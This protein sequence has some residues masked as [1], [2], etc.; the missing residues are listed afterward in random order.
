[1]FTSYLKV[2]LRNLQRSPGQTA[3]NVAG[4]AV[5][6]ACCV[7]IVLFVQDEQRFDRFHDKADRIYRVV[8]ERRAADNVSHRATTPPAMGP[9]LAREFPDAWAPATRPLPVGP[10]GIL[11][12]ESFEHLPGDTQGTIPTHE[13]G[14]RHS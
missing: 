8:N 3:I 7:L 5:G 14:P 10:A 13:P 9:T 2:A 6:M 1:M 12:P 4:L 11:A